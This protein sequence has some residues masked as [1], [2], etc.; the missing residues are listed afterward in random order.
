MVFFIT[1]LHHY[2][3]NM[4]PFVLVTLLPCRG[5]A[6][7]SHDRSYDPKSANTLLSPASPG[8]MQAFL[9]QKTWCF[10]AQGHMQL[11]HSRAELI[12]TLNINTSRP[13]KASPGTE[14]ILSCSAETV[15]KVE[16]RKERTKSPHLEQKESPVYCLVFFFYLN[17]HVKMI[18]PLPLRPSLSATLTQLP[19]E[20]RSRTIF[21]ST[22]A[23]ACS[24]SPSIHRK[25][26]SADVNTIPVGNTD[27][28]TAEPPHEMRSCWVGRNQSGGGRRFCVHIIHML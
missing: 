20:L 8:H 11:S 19:T 12:L 13:Q 16:S 23:S 3:D 4:D 28:R 26:L 6:M 5:S 18:N 24:H 2:A 27:P 22:F 17:P 9:S 7:Q 14:N 25:H 1:H 15:S 21:M 10:P